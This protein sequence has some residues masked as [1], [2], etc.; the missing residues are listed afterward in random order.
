MMVKVLV[1]GGAGFIGCALSNRLCPAGAHVVAADF[2]HPQVH[3]VR[4]RPAALHA[5]ATTLPVD[6]THEET[7]E[8]LLDHVRPDVVVHLAAE[9]G[10]GQS[11]A[12]ASRHAMVNVVGTTRMLDA[13][14]R[15]KHRPSHIVLTSSRAVYGDG[16]WQAF[17]GKVHYPGLR[18]R[19]ALE[20]KRWDHAGADGIRLTPLA[21]K[22]G[23][24]ETHPTN[25]YAATKL[26]QED[27]LR[28]WCAATETKLSILRLQNVYGPGQSVTN[29]YTG[30]LTY[31]ARQAS[32]GEMINV[33]EDGEI[34]RDFVFIDDVAAALHAAIDRPPTESR[35]VDIGSGVAS[36]ILRVATSMAAAA[37][38][39]PPTVSGDFRDGD[40][41]AAWCDISAAQADLQYSPTVGVD[42]GTERLLRWVREQTP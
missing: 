3:P 1:T 4:T 21:S 2:L 25:V 32:R 6:V 28:S 12:E 5:D 26:A 13:M 14:Y 41:R 27:I 8:P 30:V 10:T 33:F 42:E 31:F 40:V 36:T 9:T 22:A 15:S 38:A 35:L 17:D 7:W 16:A 19:A 29:S 24:T 23:S 34:V 11:L 39:P 20:G 37:K 18:R